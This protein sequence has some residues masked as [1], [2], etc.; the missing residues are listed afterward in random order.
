MQLS[1]SLRL[2]CLVLFSIGLIHLLLTALLQLLS[3]ALERFISASSARSQERFRFAL[4]TAPYF[5]AVCIAVSVAGTNYLLHENNM[6]SES[7]GWACLVGAAMVCI[8]YGIVAARSGRHM[9]AMHAHNTAALNQRISD[10][11]HVAPPL[12]VIGLFRPRI[13]ASPSVRKGEVFSKASLAVAL[14]HEESHLRNWDNLKLL[15]LSSLSRSGNRSDAVQ[16]WR[17]AAEKAADDDAVDGSRSRAI[18][19]AEAL[20]AAA[21]FASRP[22]PVSFAMEL[23]PYEC[24]LEERVNRLLDQKPEPESAR[25][26]C[27]AAIG[28][29]LLG[30]A[31]ITLL[32]A[33]HEFAELLLHL[34]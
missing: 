22:A 33:S 25:A 26:S 21:R 34:R 15:L 4:A 17:R 10:V 29:L 3:P 1:Y 6:G 20:T 24:E 31:A 16:Q 32:P 2:I 13:A 8:R 14:A 27:L 23:L 30:V 18:L 12:A 5:V 11:N 19:L 7:V 9:Y 28:L